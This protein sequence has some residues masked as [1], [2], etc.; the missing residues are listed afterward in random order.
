MTSETIK[1]SDRNGM[2]ICVASGWVE[3]TNFLW[4]ALDSPEGFFWPLRETSTFGEMTIS[5]RTIDPED[6]TWMDKLGWVKTH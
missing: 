2:L 5:D 4:V 3:A 6:Y 1:F